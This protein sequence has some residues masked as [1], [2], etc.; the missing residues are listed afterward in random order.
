MHHSRIIT[1]TNQNYRPHELICNATYLSE[2]DTRKKEDKLVLRSNIL[3]QFKRELN[4]SLKI[5]RCGV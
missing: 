3:N 2:K 4:G 5:I 1:S